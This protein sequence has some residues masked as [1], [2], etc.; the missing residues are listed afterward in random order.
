MQTEF[1][2]FTFNGEKTSENFKF[3]NIFLDKVMTIMT[4][5]TQAFREANWSVY[6]LTL[7]RAIPLFFAFGRTN[8]CQWHLI[9]M[10]SV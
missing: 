3:W 2:H 1:E 4:D 8:Y 9:I 10:K 5:L 6:L 7:G